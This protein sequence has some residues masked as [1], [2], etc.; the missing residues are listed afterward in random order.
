MPVLVCHIG[1][2]AS[3]EGIV[4]QADRIVGGGAWVNKHKDGGEVCNFL[5]CPDG[6]VYGYVETIKKKADRPISIILLG[7]S[8]DAEFI[9]HVDVIWTATDPARGGR[10]VVG[11]YRDARVYREREYF[12]KLPSAQH[13]LEK[14]RNN[15]RVRA[16][17]ENAVLLPPK[18]R[19]IRLGRGK[20]WIGQANW[21]F[22]ERQSSPDVKRFVRR[23]RQYLDAGPASAPDDKPRGRKGGWG[24]KSN[25]LRNA[26]VEEAAI[27][28]VRQHFTGH[29]IKSVEKDNLGWD[30]EAKPKTGGPTLRLEVKGLFGS[31]LMIGLTPREY[32]AFDKHRIGKMPQYRLCVVTGALS[33]KPK[34]VVFRFDAAAQGW[35]DDH[36]GRVVTP[37][38]NVVEA[39]IISLN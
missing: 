7:A 29:R 2:M 8:P 34:L 31:D 11:W 22:P 33:G 25:P 14:G 17:A 4:G 35:I 6:F 26:Q 37:S 38:V 21:W 3:Y 32:R 36:A 16:R 28:H 27:L 13:R 1:W 19:N 39:A 30:L 5:A 9:D 24:G 18:Q 15:Y 10:R 23:M 20:G 12:I